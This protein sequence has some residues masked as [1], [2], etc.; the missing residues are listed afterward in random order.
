M[1]LYI[2]EDDVQNAFFLVSTKGAEAC[3]HFLQKRDR[4][5]LFLDTFGETKEGREIC[6]YTMADYIWHT[7]PV[8]MLPFP[9][10]EDILQVMENHGVKVSFLF[11]RWGIWEIRADKIVFER[12]ES[13]RSEI[14]VRKQYLLT[15]FS[16]NGDY[17]YFNSDKGRA[18]K[19]P[20]DQIETYIKNVKIIVD[21]GLFKT[22]KVEIKF[23]E[24]NLESD[25][26]V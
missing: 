16:K 19:P 22:K 20:L 1:S 3:G 18:E 6:D 5:V 26:M 8:S 24:W 13:E 25:Y 10:A 12:S 17:L 7:H 9:S 4:L 14:D 21:L 15:E 11:S 23:S 2:T